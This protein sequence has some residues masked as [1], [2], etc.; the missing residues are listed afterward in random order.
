MKKYEV[1]E[2][3]CSKLRLIV[4]SCLVS[5]NMFFSELKEKTKATDGNLSIQLKKLKEWG[6]VEAQKM[7]KDNKAVTQ[8]K[9]TEQGLDEFEE[10]V[11]FLEEVLM[12]RE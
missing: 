2:A 3:L 9:L 7:L 8:Y 12:N 6:Y 1:P 4:I 5:Q 10:Y 11:R